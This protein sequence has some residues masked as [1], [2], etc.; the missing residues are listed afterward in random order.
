[1]QINFSLHKSASVTIALTVVLYTLGGCGS[2]RDIVGKWRMSGDS[3]AI[4][5]EFFDN[6]SV[7]IGES[8]GRY[9][10]DRDRLKIEQGFATSLYQMEF[11]DDR[12]ILRD[13]NNSKLEFTRVK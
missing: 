4:V 5:W 9:R 6:G 13:T 11:S 8:K 3:N 10:L 7:Q 12:L 2:S 1:V